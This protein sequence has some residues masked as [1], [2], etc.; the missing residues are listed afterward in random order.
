VLIDPDESPRI[1]CAA[2]REEA[3]QQLAETW[4]AWLMRTSLQEI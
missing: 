3:Q 1:G 2:T 4:R